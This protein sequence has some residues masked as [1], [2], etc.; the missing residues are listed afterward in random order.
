MDITN[1]RKHLRKSHSYH[2]SYICYCFV[3]LEKRA[4][5]IWCRICARIFQPMM[6]HASDISVIAD[7]KRNR[8]FERKR[9][10]F[11]CVPLLTFNF[12]ETSLVYLSPQYVYIMLNL[13][14]ES[15]YKES[16][17]KNVCLNFALIFS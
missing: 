7:T 2:Y 14:L 13:A 6:L 11:K 8:Y 1:A 16:F 15:H 5:Y 9:D 4:P 17:S 10:G 12:A 3:S